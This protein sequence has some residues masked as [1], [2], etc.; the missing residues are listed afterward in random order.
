LTTLT[1]SAAKSSS[2]HGRGR[3]GRIKQNEAA[4]R[5]S[6]LLFLLAVTLA[7]C[8]GSARFEGTEPTL[9]MSS[10]NELPPPTARDLVPSAGQPGLIGALDKLSVTVFGIPE[11]SLEEVQVD[12]SGRIAVP[13]IGTVE[14]GGRSAED[15]SR[16]IQERLGARYVRNPQV[17]INVRETVGHLV[18]VGGEV[19]DPGVYPVTPNMTLLSAVARAKGRT[20]FARLDDVVVFRTVNGQRMAAL[21]NLGAIERGAYRDPEIYANDIVMVGDS[22]SRRLF[23]DVLQAAPGILSPLIYIFSR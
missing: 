18:T 10:A 2:G 19:K 4:V 8:A 6:G 13:L 12:A 22:P 20:E 9:Q 11:L 17:V 21:Y 16:E 14:A 5:L 3:L 15:V 23:R 7:G 1:R